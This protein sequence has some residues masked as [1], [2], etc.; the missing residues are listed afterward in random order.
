[1]APSRVLKCCQKVFSWIPV[2]FIALVV[3]WS[4]YAYVVELCIFVYLVIFHLSFIM[5]VWS[6]WKTIFSKPANPSKEF[7]LPKADKEQYEREERPEAQQ[8][9]L[10]RVAQNLPLYT[11]TGTGA[12]RYCDRCQVIKPDRCHHCSAC[13]M[14]NNCVG[15]SNYKFFVLFLAYSLLYCLFIA[16]TVLQY[17][18]KFWASEL[19][20]S[21]AKFHVLFL[22]FVA[23]MFFI[24]ILSLFS[25]HCW[26]VGKNRS[27]IEAFRGPVFRNGPDRNG[28]SLGFSKN[29]K[30]VFGDEKK[31]W[32]LPVLGDG[33]TF[34]TRLVSLDPEQ[35]TIDVQPESTKSVADGQSCATRPLSE[36]QNRLLGNDQ[37]FTE[38]GLDADHLKL[39]SKDN[40]TVSLESES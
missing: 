23:A 11:R 32:L 39:G 29:L 8:E 21:H 2:V 33:S 5:F 31:Y 36:S 24:S 27:T 1:M 17:F 15:F 22:F 12:V 25:Y 9:I 10:K 38:D 18:I 19:P 20:D 6:Y 34:P 16:A 37:H 13:D 7:C 14:V 30:E 28:F 3:G 26:L 35:P 40:V 4:Y